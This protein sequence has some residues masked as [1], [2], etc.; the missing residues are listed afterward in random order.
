MESHWFKRKDCFA[1]L[2]H[3][4]NRFFETRRQCCRAEVTGRV[5]DNCYSRWNDCPANARDVGVRLSSLL[6][7][8]D[9][10]AFPMGTSVAYVYIIVTARGEVLAGETP[11]A[12]LSWPVVLLESA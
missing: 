11:N 3:P 7:D 4:L 9:G 1:R 12:M 2:V 8:A 6:A 10:I 5:Y